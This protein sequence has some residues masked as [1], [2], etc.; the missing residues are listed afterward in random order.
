LLA[1]A[2]A[3][4]IVDDVKLET[5]VVLRVNVPLVAP[6]AIVRT[7]P[8]TAPVFGIVTAAVLLLV[9][10]TAVPPV[11][12]AALSVTVPVAFAPP[13]TGLGVTDNPLRSGSIV[14]DFWDESPP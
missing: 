3:A 1:P 4:V 11:G 8:L 13:V 12:A 6:A 7:P 10:V 9:S 5:T 2:L 14:R